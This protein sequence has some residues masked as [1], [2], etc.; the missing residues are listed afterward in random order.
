[1][2]MERPLSIMIKMEMVFLRMHLESIFHLHQLVEQL[3]LLQ[4]VM[5]VKYMMLLEIRL[6]QLQLM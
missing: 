1:M 3:L 6:L 2:V 4:E 5:H